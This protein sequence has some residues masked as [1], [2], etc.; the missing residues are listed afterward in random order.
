MADHAESVNEN[1]SLLSAPNR[2]VRTFSVKNFERFQH[3]KDRS[4]P[5]IKLYNET[6][7]DYEFGRL[8][9][10]SKAHL[11]AIWLLASR[12]DNKI[13]HDARWI[14]T[15]INATSPVDLDLLEN[16]GFIICDKVMQ[17]ASDTLATRKQNACPE[18]E[19]ETEAEREKNP[20][21][22]QPPGSAVALEGGT[23]PRGKKSQARPYDQHPDFEQFYRTYPRPTDKGAAF[24][25]WIGALKRGQ[26]TAEQIIE[27][28]K[29]YAAQMQ[30]ENRP[31]D[32]IKHPATWLNA[33][34]FLGGPAPSAGL[35]LG[36]DLPYSKNQ[37]AG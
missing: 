24:D 5:W 21:P 8:P 28:A 12:Y 7:D 34:A 14:A 19:R 9:D 36:F 25:S 2:K 16:A 37:L 17:S 13:P 26:A 30:R 31:P 27:A 22:A 29:A 1:G 6:L 23:K 35:R 11:F 3:Y 32:K 20:P 18:T 10:A 33:D 4:P 15:K